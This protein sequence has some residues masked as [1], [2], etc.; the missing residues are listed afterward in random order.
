MLLVLDSGIG[1]LS[2]VQALREAL[3]GA[4][5]VY[6]ADNAGFP[7]GDLTDSAL[8]SRVLRVVEQA[9]TL[10]QPDAVVVACNTASTIAL[11]AL[12]S[13]FT[14]PFV[15]CVP[16][17]K[18]AAALSRNRCIGLLATPATVR[19]DYVQ[20][21]AS[22]F[23]AGCTML[24]YGSPRLAAM[25][26][27]LFQGTPPDPA[28]MKAELRGLFDQPDADRIDVVALG[29]THYAFLLP[30]LKAGFPQ[31]VHWLDPAEPV[32][33]RTASIVYDLAH[34]AFGTGQGLALTTAPV[35]HA[36]TQAFQHHGFHRLR[37]LN[38]GLSQQPN[39]TGAS[40]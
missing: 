10:L 6:L 23:A 28:A 26:E 19:R 3:P 39:T 37:L 29:C 40:E 12:R 33:R 14:V 35:T 21:L 34:L 22:R 27:D 38:L 8:T 4:G 17:I 30:A 32:A 20:D 7:Y 13:S 1:G 16:P 2:V 24:S 31:V 9:I 15:G 25:A 5:L 18:P 11:P 36:M